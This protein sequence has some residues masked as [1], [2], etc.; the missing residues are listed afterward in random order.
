MDIR[1]KLLVFFYF[2]KLLNFFFLQRGYPQAY[3][4]TNIVN[5]IV[6]SL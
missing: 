5:L 6:V 3:S 1:K 2:L 4:L